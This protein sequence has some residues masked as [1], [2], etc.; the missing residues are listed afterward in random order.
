M[1]WGTRPDAGWALGVECLG[2]G[3][4]FGTERGGSGAL[5]AA[6]LV[7]GEADDPDERDDACDPDV[8]GA[9]DP[10]VVVCVVPRTWARTVACCR[11]AG[12]AADARSV[13]IVCAAARGV[14]TLLD[15]AF[16]L[17]VPHA[18]TASVSASPATSLTARNCS[19]P[20]RWSA[21]FWH[22]IP[23]GA[24]ER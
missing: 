23:P 6:V 4:G 21:G 13:A 15:T 10:V 22:L 12:A 24:V 18:A 8:A 3:F 20:R 14:E 5:R 11:C 9:V 7:P 17:D 1:Q 16:G 2:F 19:V